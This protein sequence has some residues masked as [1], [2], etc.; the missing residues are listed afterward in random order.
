L[1]NIKKYFYVG[2]TRETVKMLFA[3]PDEELIISISIME[4]NSEK[5]TKVF[6]L[7]NKKQS[8]NAQ[9]FGANDL[10]K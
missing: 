3:K 7:L 2:L 5:S 10:K 9:S 8:L 6:D 4:I 1:D